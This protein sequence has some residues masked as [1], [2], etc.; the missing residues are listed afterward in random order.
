MD[1]RSLWALL[2]LFASQMAILGNRTMAATGNLSSDFWA[3]G[4]DFVTNV[5]EPTI[6]VDS[7]DIP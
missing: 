1:R 2:V 3:A 5:A 4:L 6:L 7:G